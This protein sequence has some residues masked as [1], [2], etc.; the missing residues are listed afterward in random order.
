[1]RRRL[2]VLSAVAA[3]AILS[4]GPASASSFCYDLDV[5]VNGNSLVNEVGCQELPGL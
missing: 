1:M 2:A 5:N 4:A 3:I